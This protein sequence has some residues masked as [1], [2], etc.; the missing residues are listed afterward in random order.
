MKKYPPTAFFNGI[1]KYTSSMPDF[2]P[3]K[4][5]NNNDSQDFLR[6]REVV[7]VYRNIE[8]NFLLND[9]PNNDLKID[10]RKA[11]GDALI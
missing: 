4:D 10:F 9:S 5:E 6:Y 2:S 7:E 3:A 11:S 1:S 8:N